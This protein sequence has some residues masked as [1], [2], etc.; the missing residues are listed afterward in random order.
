MPKISA[1]LTEEAHAIAQRRIAFKRRGLGQY[2]SSLILQEE[3]RRDAKLAAERA[4]Q[5]QLELF[6]KA[7]WDRT[8]LR[9]D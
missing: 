8:G 6:D 2:L 4:M 9:L 5:Q 7:M 1:V 3:A